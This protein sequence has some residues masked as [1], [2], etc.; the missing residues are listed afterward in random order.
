MLLLLFVIIVV[1]GCADV[2]I[3]SALNRIIQSNQS[4]ASVNQ[5]HSPSSTL[6]T[7][8]YSQSNESLIALVFCCTHFSMIEFT[9]FTGWRKFRNWHTV[10]NIIGESGIG[11]SKIRCEFWVHWVA[12]S[13][14][15]SKRLNFACAGN[16]EQSKLD[17]YIFLGKRCVAGHGPGEEE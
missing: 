2:L 15:G 5:N 3:Q 12:D 7:R 1:G 4:L 17:D 13:A 6:N 14:R 11:F 10:H 8:A 9:Q 16:A